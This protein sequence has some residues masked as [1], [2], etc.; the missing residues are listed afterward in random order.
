MAKKKTYFD[1]LRQEMGDLIDQLDLSDLHKQSLKRR[2]LDQVVWADT[3]A[4]QCRRMHYRLRGTTIVGGVILPTLVG[5]NFQFAK[6]NEFLRTWF[7]YVPFVLSQVIAVSA[8]AEE[9]F[10]YGDRWREYRRLSEDLKAEGWQ[11]LQLSG[12]YQYKPNQETIEL[13]P[14][15]AQIAAMPVEDWKALTVQKSAKHPTTHREIF[16]M[17][18]GRVESLI[19]SDVQSYITALQQKQ[20]KEEQD[21]QKLLG[22]VKAVADDTTLFARP[23]PAA[24]S[25]APNSPPMPSYGGGDSSGMGMAPTGYGNPLPESGLPVATRPAPFAAATAPPFTAPVA[26]QAVPPAIPSHETASPEIPVFVPSSATIPPLP[27]PPI[28]NPPAAP[29][30]VPVSPVV[31]PPLASVPLPVAAPVASPVADLNAA[32]VA[33]ATKLRGMST[34]E[35]PDGGNN[36]CGWTVNKVLQEAGIAPIGENPNYVPSVVEALQG[37][38]G[39]AISRDAAKAGDLVIAAGESHIGIG[40]TDGCTRVLSNSSSR[41]R[42]QWESDLDFDGSYGGTSTIYRLLQ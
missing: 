8:A 35:G 18:T 36:A 30:P 24:P 9:F 39:K 33:A 40:M 7:P 34:A 27:V 4:D 5:L 26:P 17:F 23:A 15:R 16:S 31:P 21:V 14:P 29:E 6:E 42:F 3:K 25:F 41:A 2:W 19:Q 28:A 20:A 37:S 38:R 1:Y 10:R 13:P 22:E 32:I 11:F 12:P